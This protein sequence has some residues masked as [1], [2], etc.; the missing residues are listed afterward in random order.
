MRFLKIIT[1]FLVLISSTLSF[2]QEKENALSTVVITISGMACQEGCAEAINKNLNKLSG[3]KES[4]VSYETGKAIIQFDP[5]RIPIDS[6]THQIT[7]TK[8]KNYTYVIKSIE[9][10]K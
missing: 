4:E 8:V 9:P 10:K 5:T 2:S 3:V 6:I 7:A 1:L